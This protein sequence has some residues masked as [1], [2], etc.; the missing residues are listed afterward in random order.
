MKYAVRLKYALFV[1]LIFLLAS[2]GTAYRISR[3]PGA[4]DSSYVY[5]LPYPKGKAYF[6][7]QGY[8][9]KFS[10]RGRLNLDF[11][12][13]RGATITA[14]RKGVVI[15]VEE[16]YSKG[17]VNIKYL[18]GANQVIVQ[19]DD[20]TQAMYGHL[21]HNGAL[22][23]P[24]DTVQAGQA[25]ARAGSTG[26]SALNHLHFYVWELHSGQRT[27]IPTRF[28]TKKGIRYLRPG[29]WYRAIE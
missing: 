9:S 15:K 18:N 12:M 23:A 29:R 27:V 11:K 20:G 7:I 10:H 14:A 13:K 25:I 6:L 24:G 1:P 19:H 2:C 16:R 4:N 22:V 5:R 3:K 26:Y 17:G 28:R 8:N 21:Q